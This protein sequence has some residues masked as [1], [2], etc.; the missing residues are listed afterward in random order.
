VQ[1]DIPEFVFE[2]RL[3]PNLAAFLQTNSNKRDQICGD[4][5]ANGFDWQIWAVAGSG[6]LTDSYNLFA[7]N[8]I[9]PSLAFVYWSN[10]P[11]GDHETN[12]NAITLTGS[13]LGQLIFGYL[14]DK[15]GRRKLYG[16]ELIVVIFGTLGFVQCSSGYNGS[17]DILAWIMFWRFFVGLGIGAEYPLSAVITAEY[18]STSCLW[19]FVSITLT[20][21]C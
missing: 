7:T 20:I 14:A 10:D 6:F 11:A 9:L 13:L 8:V 4:I 2:A 16:L 5:D 18:V 3:T 21:V 15:Y 12:I 17:M 19:I 1:Q